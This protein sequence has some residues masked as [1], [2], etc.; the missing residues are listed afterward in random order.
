[1][2]QQQQTC[3]IAWKYLLNNMGDIKDLAQNEKKLKTI[4]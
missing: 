1:M 2:L 3:H 4:I